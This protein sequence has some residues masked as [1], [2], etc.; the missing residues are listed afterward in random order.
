MS[1]VAERFEMVNGCRWVDEVVTN[2]PYV[3]DE[4]YLKYVL[5]KYKIDFIVHGKTNQ[6]SFIDI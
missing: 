2:V 3:I 6:A 4:E 1:S 5:D